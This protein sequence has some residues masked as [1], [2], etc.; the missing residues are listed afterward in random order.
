MVRNTKDTLIKSSQTDPEI[1]LTKN[2]NE[3]KFGMRGIAKN[4]NKLNVLLACANLIMV[5]RVQ[6]DFCPVKG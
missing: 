2:E 1:H 4:L 6:K 3:W 5:K